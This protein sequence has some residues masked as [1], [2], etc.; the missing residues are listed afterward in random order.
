MLKLR[1]LVSNTD[2]A[3]HLLRSWAH[4]LPADAAFDGF[5]ISSNAVYPF[6]RDGRPCYLR[7]APR[8]LLLDPRPAVDGRRRGARMSRALLPGCR[9]GR[10][11]S[12]PSTKRAC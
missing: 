12:W 8:R 10:W 3:S 9:D 5:R 2:L 11:R 6:L 7:F 1:S 4:D